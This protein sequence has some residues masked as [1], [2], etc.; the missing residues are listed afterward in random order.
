MTRSL[1]RRC[2]AAASA[3]G[4]M[5]VGLSALVSVPPAGADAPGTVKI[6]VNNQELVKEPGNVDNDPHVDCGFDIVFNG[7]DSLQGQSVTA[8]I[9]IQS[10]SS[11]VDQSVFL[12]SG[13][14][15]SSGYLDIPVTAGMLNFLGT[16]A[17]HTENGNN[18]SEKID[19]ADP[20]E[21][22]Y[23]VTLDTSTTVG[24]D[25]IAKQKTFWIG[26]CEAA[27]TIATAV[28]H[29]GSGT[30]GT[31]FTDTATLAQTSTTAPTGTVTFRAYDNSHCSGA[32]VFTSV[33]PIAGSTVTSD[34]FTPQ[35]VGT[36]YWVASYSGDANNN[37]VAG[38]CGDQGET[39]TVHQATPSVVT[40][41]TTAPDSTATAPSYVD[42]ATVTGYHP[43]GTVTF[44]AWTNSGCSGNPVFTSAGRPLGSN[45]TA[46]SGEFVP[47]PPTTSTTYFFI[48]SYSG[49]TNN[50]A[51]SG[52]CTDAG[53]S[54][55]FTPGATQSVIST[56]ASAASSPD[57]F[58][59][60]ATVTG[61]T[62]P[63]A[64]TGQ[65]TFQVYGPNDATCTG[66]FVTISPSSSLAADGTATSGPFTAPSAGTYTF[67]ASYGGDAHNTPAAGTCSSAHE[68][69]VVEKASPAISTTEA[70]STTTSGS[71]TDTATLTGLAT[72]HAPSGT[73]TFRVYGPNDATCTGTAVTLTPA[74]AVTGASTTSGLFTP[75]GPGT[76]TFVASYSGDAFNSPVAG[77][78]SDANERFTVASPPPVVIPP[79]V[80]PPTVIVP[81]VLPSTA[82]PAVTIVKTNDA[83]G[84]PFAK[85]NQAKAPSDSVDFQAVITNTSGEAETITAI[86][87]QYGT[88]SPAECPGLIGTVL[89]PGQSVTCS[90]TIPG[91][92]PPAGTA[93]TN[94][95]TVNV[96]DTSNQVASATDT[97]TVTS[98]EAVG[99][100]GG[101]HQPS[102][103]PPAAV[104]TATPPA[105][106]VQP[107]AGSRTLPFTGANVRSMV[108][109]ALALLFLGAALLLKTYRVPGAKHYA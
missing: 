77:H 44:Q 26:G 109:A 11:P 20:N 8:N 24:G 102:V 10:P 41:V 36:Y 81:V 106:A 108:L 65:V 105:T 61:G 2:A 15:N 51:V 38:S 5:A 95:I 84:N 69:F 53:E 1:W 13:T 7:F 21:I 55:T 57:T 9:Q 22:T 43:T 28:S 80:I 91:Y 42:T 72:G 82:V 70:A 63:N 19:T 52:H 6:V 17:N 27:P 74:S 32:A 94:T 97:S 25:Q 16:V 39:L 12:K 33:K 58:T 99:A 67:I 75:P 83:G 89:S 30:I 37:P 96:K 40:S 66:P 47:T 73:V 46:T 76:Y 98:P 29:E 62:G 23:H 18:D 64:P 86:A 59:D 103:L 100:N 71:F 85:A 101:N 34:G 92:A 104:V 68:S 3:T 31:T 49:D 90:F 45:G 78:C 48:A 60:T 54:I 4:L 88:V 79:V 87:D 50:V 107:A 93:L 14:I 56:R 35:A